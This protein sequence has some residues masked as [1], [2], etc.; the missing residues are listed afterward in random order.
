MGNHRL[1]APGE[2]GTRSSCSVL[3]MG[4]LPD[5]SRIAALPASTW[6]ELGERLRRAGFT[7]EYL[8]GAWQS[9][10]R[11][12]E[13]S[14]QRPLLLWHLRRRLDPHGYAHRMFIL[15]DPISQHEAIDV[16]GDTLLGALIEA[17]LLFRPEPASVVSAF[18]LRVFRGLL[19]L[20]DDLSHRGDAVFGVGPGT[21]AF[22]APT[23]RGEAA[24]ALDLGCGAGGA[25]LWF[26]R[27]AR[28]V[29]ATDINPRA[30][31]FVKINAAV[32]GIDNIE[33]RE[34]DLF[35]PVAGESFDIIISQPPYVPHAPAAAPAT[36]L[37][38][39]PRGNEIL[40]R[41]LRELPRH[42]GREGR[43]LLVF[44][45]PILAASG[46]APQDLG[47]PS[48]G[49]MRVLLIRGAEVSADA[50]SIRH[51]AP[52][53]RRGVEQFDRAATAMREHLHSI[54]VRGFCP[55]LCVIEH[56]P[57]S[58]GW[59]ETVRAGT[60]LWNEISAPVIDRLM[61]DLTLAGS[62]DG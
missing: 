45:A 20:C 27:H 48:D 43:A 52:E 10:M 13:A 60:T 5:I 57:A 59:R 14:L 6:L 55:A 11:S 30:L 51:A 42:L 29:I 36:Y 47:V 28:R 50:Y 62:T 15:R 39:G 16:L 61:T 12:Y 32:N 53:L 26:C 33:A 9:G 40:S 38:G 8:E 19:V 56:A 21:A 3:P 25:A 23:T 18:D 2:T 34:G 31:A 46:D 58:R 22:Y 35:E 4:G 54:G 49:D 17:G 24:A 44:D 41:V 1:E 7:A 37:F